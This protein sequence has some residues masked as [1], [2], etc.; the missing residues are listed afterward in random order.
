MLATLIT[1]DWKKSF[2]KLLGS[3]PPTLLFEKAQKWKFG[4]T[5]KKVEKNTYKVISIHKYKIYNF[6]GFL[7]IKSKIQ[8]PKFYV[9]QVQI[10][11]F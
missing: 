3:Q 7:G 11:T 1:R 5:K 8:N 9:F 6:K 2:E 4:K 10:C